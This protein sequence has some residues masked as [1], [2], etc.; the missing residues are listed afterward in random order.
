M[1]SAAERPAR[2]DR[3]A[4]RALLFDADGV[5][6]FPKPGA[7]QAFTR[8]GNGR[9]GFVRELLAEEAKTMT[10]QVDLVDV[11]QPVIERFD[12]QITAADLIAV[13]CQ[14]DPRPQMLEVVAE[15]RAAGLKTA[16]ATNQQPYRGTWMQQNLPYADYFDELCYSF[17]LG[18]AKPDPAFFTEIV[19]RLGVAPEEAVMIDDL[20]ENVEAARSAGLHGIICAWTDGDDALRGRLGQLGVPGF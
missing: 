13:W 12:L 10:G 4:I 18:V 1:S 16:L 14:I 11:L 19:R 7:I 15:A 3:P 8:L 5:L 2:E 20:P 9:H 6:Q 17:E